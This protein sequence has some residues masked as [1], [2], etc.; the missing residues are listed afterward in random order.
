MD[1]NPISYYNLII[2]PTKILLDNMKKRKKEIFASYKDKQG[3]TC[4]Q[5]GSHS[6]GNVMG[7]TLIIS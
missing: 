7:L 4:Y 6:A 3:A 1:L 5:A 2:T